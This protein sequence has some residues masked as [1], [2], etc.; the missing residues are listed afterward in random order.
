[1][2]NAKMLFIDIETSPN[3]AYV[4]R[5][6]K[7]NVSL[8]QLVE[9]TQMISFAAKWRNRK[10]VFFHS[11]FHDGHEAM[12]ERAF[13]LIDAA[14]IVV[15]YNGK[16][17][18][19]PHLNREFITNGFPGPPSPVQQIDLL[20]TMRKRFRFASNKL[21]HVTQQLG[22][23]G[24]VQHTGFQ[25]WRDCMAGDP[26]AWAL[27]RKYNRADVTELEDLYEKVKPWIISHPHMGLYDDDT[28]APDVCG[29]CESPNITRQ[30]Y[31]YTGASKFQRYR[32]KDCNGWS[33][34]KKAIARVEARPVN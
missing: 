34:G 10:Q 23:A 2:A 19:M 30:G 26:K 9:T 31:S 28:D 15:H 13:H 3:L 20:H 22:Q 6:F 27:M 11:D 8:P 32:C 14:D 17:F 29:R 7:E 21:D 33:R 1:M 18:D 24:K 4:W 5:M 12:V 16:S 25:L